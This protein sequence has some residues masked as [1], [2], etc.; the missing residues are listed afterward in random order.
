MLCQFVFCAA[1]SAAF[2]FLTLS[3]TPLTQAFGECSEASL[4]RARPDPRYCFSSVLIVSN[5]TERAAEE[6][7]DSLFCIAADNLEERNEFLDRDPVE[8]A[9][10]FAKLESRHRKF[11]WPEA[12]MTMLP[13]E[14]DADSP[15]S[16]KVYTA[17]TP[18]W[19]YR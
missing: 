9:T 15:F 4:L 16:A 8:N 11:L 3:G 2:S 17:G 7:S 18:I 13:T 6:T 5:N 10:A 12:T 1:N 19:T 14:V